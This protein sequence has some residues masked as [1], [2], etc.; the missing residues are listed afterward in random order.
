MD[1]KALKE[2][3]SVVGEEYLSTRKDVLLTYSASAST[4]YERR[5]PAAVVRPANAQQVSEI[6]RIANRHGIPVTPR[7]GGS[8]LQGEVIPEDG[9]LVID[10]LRLD[11]IEVFPNLR[12]VRV[13]A[14]V[15]FGRLD[16]HLMK[17]NSW[18]PIYPGSSLSATLAGN[19]AVNGSGFGS[20]RFGCIAEMV[21]GLE[22][23][24]PDGTI[25]ETG[26]E[27]NPNAPGPF[28]RYAFGPDITGLF[29]GSLGI[30]GIITRVSLKTFKR[31]H[32][33][34][35]N[36]YGFST[37][38]DAER[39]I[40]ELKENE[41]S[42]LWTAIYEGRILDFFLD[43]V[44]E[45]YGVPQ[46]DWP[47]YTVSLAIGRVREDQLKH[48]TQAAHEIAVDVGGHVIGIRELPQ[49]E[50][51]DRMLELARSSYVHGWHWRILYHH[52]TPSQ[53]HRTLEE[54][55]PLMDEFGVLG[56]TAGFQSGHASYNYYP[57]IYYDP[58]DAEDEAKA[59]AAHKE[60]AKRLFK[61]GA[62][63][64][65]LAPYWAGGISEMNG[66]FDFLRELKQAVDPNNIMHPGVLL[67]ID[68]EA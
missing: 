48:D 40:L 67:G 11:E 34:D 4:S 28:L 14:G 43:M 26:S 19:V 29:I 46:H 7:S 62:V 49:G 3:R 35:F 60:F 41:V 10:L 47:D 20:G 50:W 13:G 65:K 9:G 6:L 68:R 31:M 39:F 12:S 64:F 16:K 24:L 58:Q 36:T 27:A 30:F 54:M 44:G 18:V 59:K 42:T 8:S 17:H 45:E 21:L 2:L 15:T 5:F 52:Q 37:A 22:V 38:E 53:W 57:Q 32:F 51:N 56:H 1:K 61:T 33:F 55:W 25:I 66:Y 63:P 23:V